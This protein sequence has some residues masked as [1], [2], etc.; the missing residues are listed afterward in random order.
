MLQTLE[1]LADEVGRA[2][3]PLFESGRFG[4]QTKAD[5]SPVTEADFLADKIIASGLRRFSDLPILSEEVPLSDLSA[6]PRQYWLIDPID[7]TKE[8]IAKRPQFT[9]N[10]ALIS[11]GVPI[12]GVVYA[13]ALGELYAGTLGESFRINRQ[14]VGPRQWPAEKTLVCSRSHPEAELIAF[15]EREGYRHSLPTGSS[16]KFCLVAAGKAH[17]YPRFR[18]LSTWDTAAGHAIALAG[19]CTVIELESGQPLRYSYQ[20]LKTPAFCVLA[21]GIKLRKS[22]LDQ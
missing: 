3:L 9:I 19:G 6:S 18:S 13:P 4:T 16:F 15:M 22:S 10:I 21:P 1:D 20:Q 11:D 5:A 17:A 7:G 8:F 12:S 2:I 14:A